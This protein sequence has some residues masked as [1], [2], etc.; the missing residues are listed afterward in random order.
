MQDVEGGANVLMSHSRRIRRVLRGPTSTR[1]KSLMGFRPA[2]R[3]G[4]SRDSRPTFGFT[5]R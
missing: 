2:L 3:D 1:V 5:S 4:G